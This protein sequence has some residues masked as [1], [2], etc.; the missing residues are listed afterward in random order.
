MN[1]SVDKKL[2]KFLWAVTLSYVPRKMCNPLGKL[3]SEPEV[4][5]WPVGSQLWVSKWF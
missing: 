5:T 4:F 1:W 3:T 2:A